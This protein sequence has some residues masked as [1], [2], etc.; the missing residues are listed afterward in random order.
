[1]DTSTSNLINHSWLA[2]HRTR[3]RSN[4]ED[5]RECQ[6]RSMVSEMCTTP[7]CLDSHATTRARCKCANCRKLSVGIS[8]GRQSSSINRAQLSLN[9]PVFHLSTTNVL[10]VPPNFSTSSPLFLLFHDSTANPCVLRRAAICS[11][12]HHTCPRLPSHR[13]P[14]PHYRARKTYEPPGQHRPLPYD[15]GE[16]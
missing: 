5:S 13:F 7:P 3:S 14:R 2:S 8:L 4:N 6:S 15:T 1:M 11:R 9:Y 16:F 12:Q 10:F